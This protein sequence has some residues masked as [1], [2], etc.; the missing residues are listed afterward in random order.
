MSLEDDTNH[1]ALCSSNG[2]M[3]QSYLMYCRQNREWEINS[4]SISAV[5]SLYFILKLKSW[6]EADRTSC[7]RNETYYFKFGDDH[8]NAVQVSLITLEHLW[9]NCWSY[10]L[11]WQI[12]FN[13][14]SRR[15]GVILKFTLYVRRRK[16][17]IAVYI[18]EIDIIPSIP[19]ES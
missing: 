18:Y 7:R 8:V 14:S 1:V 16:F 5:N 9:D 17:A 10:H 13:N 19:K 11:T 15:I 12:M 2:A 4:W 6:P 3:L